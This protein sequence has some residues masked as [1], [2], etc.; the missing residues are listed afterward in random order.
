ML[1]LKDPWDAMNFG[2]AGCPK[3]RA[4]QGRD[5]GRGLTRRT[6]M[7]DGRRGQRASSE[8]RFGFRSRGKSLQ[9]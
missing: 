3:Y 2:A 8:R 9:I 4:N 6:G 1:N 7:P 5:R